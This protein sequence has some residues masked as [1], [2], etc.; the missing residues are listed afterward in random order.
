MIRV[1]HGPDL[2]D[3]AGGEVSDDVVDTNEGAGIAADSG[4]GVEA[5]PAPTSSGVADLGNA[6][7]PAA[8]AAPAAQ[9][10]PDGWQSIRQAASSLGLDLS[11]YPDDQRALVHLVQQA[12]RAQQEDYYARLGRG[13]APHA[14]AVRA[15]IAAKQAPAPTAPPAWKPPDFDRNWLAFVEKDPETGVFMPKNHGV[16]DHVVQSINARQQWEQKFH[17]DPAAMLQPLIEERAGAI[18]DERIT[19]QLDRLRNE[20]ATSAIFSANSQWL[21]QPDAQG[22]PTRTLSPTGS[23][24]AQHVR[25]LEG[26]GLTDPYRIDGLAQRLVRAE[27]IEQQAAQAAAAADPSS[28]QAMGHPN[29]NPLQALSPQQRRQT[30]AATEPS[31]TGLS[32]REALNRNMVAAGVS[33]A[34]FNVNMLG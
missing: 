19:A 27:I 26:A 30:P 18:A 1:L 21:Y 31:T 34:D 25:E 16:P 28:A 4:S 9:P 12:Q 10:T 22:R 11:Q 3:M 8:P 5:D 2:A 29:V 7:R 20:Q 13:I 32:L 15:A 33:D 14:D 24:Y 23:R 17:E 6:P